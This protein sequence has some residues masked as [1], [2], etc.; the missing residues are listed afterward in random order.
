M[1]LMSWHTLRRLQWR[2]VRTFKFI[3]G[4]P[5]D[6]DHSM[7]Q[8]AID[9]C[10]EDGSFVCQAQGLLFQGF[11]LAYDPRHDAAEWLRFKVVTSDLMPVEES[12]II[13]M[14]D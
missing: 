11:M 12:A 5:L 1:L 14:L 13:K 10:T 2:K 7:P 9:I 8:T 6:M 4:C 3:S